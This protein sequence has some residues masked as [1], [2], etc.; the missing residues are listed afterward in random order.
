MFL[1]SLILSYSV[2]GGFSSTESFLFSSGLVVG[3][4]EVEGLSHITTVILVG[5]LSN[6]SMCNGWERLN[7]KPT[8]TSDADVNRV[9]GSDKSTALHCDA[10][11]GAVNVTEKGC[12]FKVEC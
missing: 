5:F 12:S 9:C 6:E 10:V 3:N 11:G 7:P 8:P 1:V 2:F 4:A